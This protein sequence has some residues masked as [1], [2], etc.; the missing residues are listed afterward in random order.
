MIHIRLS[1]SP[2]IQVRGC[3][4]IPFPFPDL[5]HPPTLCPRF[6][7]FPSKL[8]LSSVIGPAVRLPHL[9][10]VFNL[11]MEVCNYHQPLLGECSSVFEFMVRAFSVLSSVYLVMPIVFSFS[12]LDFLLACIFYLAF[13]RLNSD[14]RSETYTGTFHA[15]YAVV[16]C[17]L[18]MHSR[19]PLSL[20]WFT[21]GCWIFQ[22]VDAGTWDLGYALTLRHTLIEHQGCHFVMFSHFLNCRS[23]GKLR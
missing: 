9:E 8:I 6:L 15:K 18:F 4:S 1:L 16:R 7:P 11:D 10:E 14:C 23:T 19:L 2:N 20:F 21:S 12:F 22:S 17:F 13:R 5:F 3:S